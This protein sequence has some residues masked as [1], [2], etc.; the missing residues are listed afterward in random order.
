MRRI[1]AALLACLF[2]P[3]QPRRPYPPP[4]RR[5]APT[6]PEYPA[7]LPPRRSARPE[8]TTGKPQIDQYRAG[9]FIAS[10]GSLWNRPGCT[11]VGDGTDALNPRKPLRLWVRHIQPDTSRSGGSGCWAIPT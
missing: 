3:Q 9:K 8:A 6:Q 10:Y 1:L 2:L 5:S 11:M 7:T 4:P